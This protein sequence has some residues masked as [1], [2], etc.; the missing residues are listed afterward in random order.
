MDNNNEDYFVQGI[1]ELLADIQ[2]NRVVVF[3]L[4]KSRLTQD[5]QPAE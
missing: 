4:S 3:Y 5:I 1:G 2:G